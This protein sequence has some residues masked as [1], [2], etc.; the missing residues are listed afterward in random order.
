MLVSPRM[1]RNTGPSPS[2]YTWCDDSDDDDSDDDDSDD[3]GIDSDGVPA[4]SASE[5]PRGQRRQE[6]TWSG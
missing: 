3:D 1:S 4:L 6:W 2:T 5:A